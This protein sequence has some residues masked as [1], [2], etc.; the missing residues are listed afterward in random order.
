MSVIELEKAVSQL[1]PDELSL[2]SKWFSAYQQRHA[3][4]TKLYALFEEGASYPASSPS[5]SFA[6]AE[7]MMKALEHEKANQ[8]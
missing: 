6:A 4:D 1:P 5:D 3:C 8:K 2:F 7:A